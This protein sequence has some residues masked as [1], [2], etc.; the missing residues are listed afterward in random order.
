MDGRDEAGRQWKN[1][2]WMG[3]VDE[4]LFYTVNELRDAAASAKQCW[5]QQLGDE[6]ADYNP[7]DNIMMMP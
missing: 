6:V 3:K 4:K 2:S 1:S 5:C 7:T